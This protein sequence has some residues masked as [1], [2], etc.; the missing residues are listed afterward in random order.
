MKRIESYSEDYSAYGIDASWPQ[1]ETEEPSRRLFNQ[2][3]ADDPEMP[4]SFDQ[5]ETEQ[6]ALTIGAKVKRDEESMAAKIGELVVASNEKLMVA[7]TI[8]NKVIENDSVKLAKEQAEAILSPAKEVIAVL[9]VIKNI[10]P[11]I[12]A[13]T[14]IFT[15]LIKLEAD[16]RENDKSIA[17]LHLTMTNLLFELSYL[18]P[19]FEAANKIKPMLHQFLE[20]VCK[21]MH[22]FGNFCDVYYKQRSIVKMIRSSSYKSKLAGYATAFE[23][24]KKDLKHL[25]ITKTAATV[26]KMDS[27]V[28]DVSAKL[29]QV[30][31]FINMQSRKEKWVGKKIQELGGE[32]KVVSDD[33]LLAKIGKVVKEEIN[34]QIKYALRENIDDAIKSNFARFSLKVE[35]AM[36]EIKDAVQRSTETIMTRLDS[37]PHD[38]IEDED[39]KAVWK[40]MNW[41]L[42]CKSRHFVDAVHHHFAEKFAKYTLEKGEIHPEHWTLKFLSNIICDAIDED[43]SGYLSVH[44]V[45]RFFKACPRGWTTTQWM[46]YWAAGWYLNA[47][48]Y[49][50]RCMALLD[51][52]EVA[53]KNVMPQ[54]KSSLKPY[55]KKECYGRIRLML[56]GLYIDNLQYHG[57]G[58]V[59]Y[60]S[61]E[62]F[63]RERMN[64]EVNNMKAHLAKPN[65][66]LDSKEAVLAV[67]GTHRVEISVLPLLF[68]VL[69]RHKKII[70]L[71][72][73]LLL[74][75]IEFDAMI[76][77]IQNISDVFETRFRNLLESWR[78]QRLD[79]KYQS[80]FFETFQG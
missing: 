5:H 11:V 46:A 63:R 38:L 79:T 2:N 8:I 48:T 72:S 71:A 25:M 43:G 6:L 70:D 66:D 64:V 73:K 30:L 34:P 40:D 78:Q 37:G 14:T 31:A 32:E 19:S 61:L 18:Q 67:L 10:H 29:D 56:E 60:E 24:H 9:N 13:V 28:R 52:I 35:T 69:Q 80:I 49:R 68:L 33:K 47:V 15:A 44:E 4:T 59:E 27:E 26:T 36:N 58:G 62:R 1:T 45:D 20:N 65:Y 41:R 16:R 39:I 55:L 21:T 51:S 53:S 42:S 23:D 17:V 75:E 77:C 76:E 50:H 57:E 3:G 22:Q 54:N 7:E 74:Q 12:G